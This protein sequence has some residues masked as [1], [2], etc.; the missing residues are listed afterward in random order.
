MA[1]CGSVVVENRVG[2][3]R[4]VEWRRGFGSVVVEQEWSSL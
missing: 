4:V 1:G 2:G 3:S